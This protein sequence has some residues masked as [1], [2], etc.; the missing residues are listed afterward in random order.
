MTT[1]IVY[2][3]AQVGRL[4]LERDEARREICRQKVEETKGKKPPTA[5][6]EYAVTRGWDCF[7]GRGET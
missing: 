4:M 7:E 1:H 2:V 5:Y 6:A 3:L